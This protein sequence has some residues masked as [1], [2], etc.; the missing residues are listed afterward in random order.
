MIIAS[1]PGWGDLALTHLVVDFNGTAAY[2]GQMKREVTELLTALSDRLKVFIVTSDTYETVDKEAAAG[3]FNTIEVHKA[4]SGIEKAALVRHLE[5]ETVVAIGNGANDA[6]MLREAALG[7][8]IVGEEGCAA[9]LLKDAD[10]VVGDIIHALN[11][12]VYPE[13]LVATLRE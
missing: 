10:I 9:T 2:G 12:L 13:R 7:I 1:I 8:A 6:M 5:P 3:S 4:S 11:L